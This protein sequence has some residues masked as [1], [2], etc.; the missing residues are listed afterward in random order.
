MLKRPE[1][2]AFFTIEFILLFSHAPFYSFY[3][4]FLKSLNF[5]TTE[6]GFLWAMGVV[7]E[8]VM[9]AYA[10]TFFKYFSWRSLVAVCL[11][12][13]SIRWLLVAIFSHYFIGQLFAQCLHAF[14]FGLFHLIAMRLIFQ[15]FSIG[16]QGRGQAFYSTMWGLGVAFG[17]ILAGHYWKIL[18]GEYIFMIAAL[19]VLFGLCFVYW[20]PKQIEKSVS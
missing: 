7:S 5:S 4:N 8:I 17:S 13:T 9:F 18:T 16:Q 3:S 1:V 20:L 12:L 11:I 10:T 2:A 6:I 19:V 15:N 14:S